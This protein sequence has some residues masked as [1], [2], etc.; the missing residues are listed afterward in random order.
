MIELC[1]FE[2]NKVKQGAMFLIGLGVA[3]EKGAFLAVAAIVALS[4]FLFDKHRLVNFHN[5]YFNKTMLLFLIYVGTIVAIS[6]IQ[7]DFHSIKMVLRDFEKIASFLII[8]I[9]LGKT[10]KAFFFGSLGFIIG[11][12]IGEATVVQSFIAKTSVFGNRY[13]GIYGHP[14]SLGG[15]MELAI[16]FL[17]FSI[18]QYRE[19]AYY[20]V[21]TGIALFSSFFCL[22]ASGSRGAILAV[23]GEFLTFFAIYFYRKLGIKSCKKYISIILLVGVVCLLI[24]VYFNHRGYDSERIL[25]WTAAWQMFLDHP[26]IGVGFSN[27]K[28]IYQTT[29]ISPLAKEPNLPHCHNFYLHILSTTGIVGTVAYFNLLIGQLKMSIRNS[30][31]EYKLLGTNINIGDMFGIIICGML[32]HNVV[33]INAVWRFYLLKLFFFWALCCLRFKEIDKLALENYRIDGE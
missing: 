5:K 32:I 7:G 27:W 33:E 18:Y 1:G 6:L 16:P 22:F 8:Y 10:E 26:I 25:L 3:I 31:N 20:T 23:I 4:V 28:E 30:I 29:Y 19:K 2:K 17:L 21:L 9:L 15:V 24:F 13:G 12:L 14:N 11:I